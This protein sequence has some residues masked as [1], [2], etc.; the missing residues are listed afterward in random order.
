MPGPVAGHAPPAAAALRSAGG[1]PQGDGPAAALR[2]GLARGEIGVHYQP[3]V[4]LSDRR[5]VMVEALARWHRPNAPV[6][7]E[8]FVPLAESAGLGRP[9]SVSVAGTAAT[10]IG[11]LWPRLRLGVSI[12]LPLEQ[13][14]K[15]DLQSWLR[16]VLGHRGLGPRQVALELTETTPV[17]DV[18]QLHRTLLR[19]QQAG[20]RVL[21]D[22]VAL[23]DGR[24]RLHR[25]PF[26]GL[27]LD[28]SLVERVPF[29]AHIR[30]EVRRL[31]KAAEARGQA[32][33]AEGVS[34]RR[35]WGAIRD[36]GVHYAQGYAVGRPL[37]AGALPGWWAGWRG[38][39]IE[40]P[41]S[42]EGHPAD[43][44]ARPGTIRSSPAL[45]AQ[46]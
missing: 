42:G 29:E 45:S 38:G 17:L 10:D 9:L 21:L 44:K 26:S 23:G 16:Q 32:V 46:P 41:A 13:L 2:E 11:R 33:I 8:T 6:S 27:K 19:L 24:T 20:Y 39:R 1:P 28:R 31:A 34:D 5:P 37:P 3:V 14:L 4:R 7:P 15:P 43:P 36:L 35:I 30:Q 18:T 22:D 12:N 40:W 25:L